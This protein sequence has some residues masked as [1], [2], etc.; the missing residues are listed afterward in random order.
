[1]DRAFG[2][3][4]K[5]QSERNPKEIIGASSS[6][7]SRHEKLNPRLA[8]GVAIPDDE[9]GD[10][11]DEEDEACKTRRGLELRSEL[12]G[13]PART[14]QG[15]KECQGCPTSFTL[16]LTGKGGG[17]AKEAE[18]GSKAQRSEAQRSDNW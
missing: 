4:E 1:M 6:G 8:K 18:P 9:D 16:N 11:K 10:L 14:G 13:S 17:A 12:S 7:I 15:G 5:T 3:S 2:D